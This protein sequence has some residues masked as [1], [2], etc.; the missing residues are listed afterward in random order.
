[1]EN[2]DLQ[3]ELDLLLA[4][5][6]LFKFLDC[7]KCTDWAISLLQNG[8]ESDYIQAIASQYITDYLEIEHYFEKMVDELGL[9]RKDDSRELFQ[10]FVSDIAHQVIDGRM[11]PIKSLHMMDAMSAVEVDYIADTV[12][13]FSYLAYDISSLDRQTS[14]YTGLTH[15]NIEGV[16]KDEMKMLLYAQTYGL[17]RIIDLIFCEKCVKFRHVMREVSE[18]VPETIYTGC[19]ECHSEEYLAWHRV[20]DRKQILQ[21]LE[22]KVVECS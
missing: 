6:L 2:K 12:D 3:T 10:I 22:K 21:L 20:D 16:I 5:R 1:M 4:G 11:E 13:Q 7:E 17:D 15:D 14:F 8:Y 9:I 19:E 18:F